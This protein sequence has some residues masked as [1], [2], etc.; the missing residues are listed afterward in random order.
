MLSEVTPEDTLD[1]ERPVVALLLPLVPLVVPLELPLPLLPRGE[2]E[3][4]RGEMV[5]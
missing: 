2:G 3:L 5:R 4:E 1:D